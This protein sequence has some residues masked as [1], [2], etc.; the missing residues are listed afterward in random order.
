MKESTGNV[1]VVVDYST[2]YRILLSIAG[3]VSAAGA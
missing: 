3:G 2:G 1:K